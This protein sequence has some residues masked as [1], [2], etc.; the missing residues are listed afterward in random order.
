MHPIDII[1][2]RR[3]VR[4]FKDKLVPWDNIYAIIKCGFYAPAAG[5]VHCVKYIVVRDQA[6]RN[7]IADA[8]HSQSWIA[9]APVVICVIAEGHHLRRHYG[10][11]GEKLYTIQNTAAS[12]ENMI[13]AAESLGLSTCWVGAFD[14]DKLRS[15]L[16]MPEDSNVHAVLPIGFPDEKPK[17]PYKP[18]VR[19]NIYLEKWWSGSKNPP[20]GYYSLN[21]M[22]SVKGAEDSIK[23]VARKILGKDYKRK[24]K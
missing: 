3:S 2:K 7:A 22:K 17:I 5:N 16:S 14:E 15:L 19:G 4:K 6:N 23:K 12:I 11:R 13:I 20:L 21:V 18:W 9:G 10:V 8:C 1:L 24:K